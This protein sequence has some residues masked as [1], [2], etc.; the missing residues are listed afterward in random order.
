MKFLREI[1][2]VLKKENITMEVLR[3]KKHYLIKC[4][5]LK[6]KEVISTVSSSS[7]CK[8]LQKRVIADIKRG[9]RDDA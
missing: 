9:L 5:S 1:R 8:F 6:R 3:H 4:R 2:D 7:A